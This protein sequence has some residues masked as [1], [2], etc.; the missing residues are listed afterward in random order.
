MPLSL[1]GIHWVGHKHTYLLYEWDGEHV[2]RAAAGTAARINAAA[3]IGKP[4]LAYLPVPLSIPYPL[5]LLLLL[6]QLWLLLRLLWLGHSLSRRLWWARHCVMG[7]EV[8]V[9]PWRGVE[10]VA[11]IAVHWEWVWAWQWARA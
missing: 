9:I 3:L 4:L 10:D 8:K 7:L 11:E 2:E 1:A 6:L 5:L